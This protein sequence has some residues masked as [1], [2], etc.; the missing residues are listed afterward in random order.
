MK[1]KVFREKR[2]SLETQIPKETK[3]KRTTKKEKENK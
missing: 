1:K 2:K 3:K